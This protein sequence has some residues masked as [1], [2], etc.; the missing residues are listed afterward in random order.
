MYTWRRIEGIENS[1]AP[2]RVAASAVLNVGAGFEPVLPTA[3]HKVASE[4]FALPAQSASALVSECHRTT[5]LELAQCSD[6]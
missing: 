6:R 5:L 1:L 2:D 4:K 3:C